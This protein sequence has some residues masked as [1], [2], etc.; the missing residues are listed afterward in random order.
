MGQCAPAN[1]RKVTSSKGGV[2]CCCHEPKVSNT[3]I[4]GTVFPIDFKF[5]VGLPWAKVHREKA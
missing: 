2:A 4:S 1:R 5:D 3:N